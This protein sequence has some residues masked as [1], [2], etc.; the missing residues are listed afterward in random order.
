MATSG[1]TYA[2]SKFFA[3]YEFITERARALA[4]SASNYI[5]VFCKV[6]TQVFNNESLHLALRTNSKKIKDGKNELHFQLPTY[7]TVPSRVAHFATALPSFF[8]ADALSTVLTWVTF[9]MINF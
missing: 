2:T 8:L 3:K 7:F 4:A 5:T 1:Q 6:R 9:A